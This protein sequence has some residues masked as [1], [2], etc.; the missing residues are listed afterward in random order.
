MNIAFTIFT[1]QKSGTAYQVTVGLIG[2]AATRD[3]FKT[4]QLCQAKGQNHIFF[5][6]FASSHLSIS[7]NK[8]WVEF[9]ILYNPHING[10]LFKFLYKN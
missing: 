10:T 9:N 8:Y 5:S 6:L 3:I 2:S 7:N 4:E 1:K